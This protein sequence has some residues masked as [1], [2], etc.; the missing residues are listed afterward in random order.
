MSKKR[1]HSGQNFRLYFRNIPRRE[2]NGHDYIKREPLSTLLKYKTVG[3]LKID[4]ILK[5]YFD[6]STKL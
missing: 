3:T 2:I 6:V 5:I 4:N 1:A